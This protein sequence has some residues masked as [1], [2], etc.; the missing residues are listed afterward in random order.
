MNEPANK[1]IA[2]EY[3]EIQAPESQMPFFLDCYESF[4]W[5][6]DSRLPHRPGVLTV[7]RDRRRCNKAELTR[8]QRHFEACMEEITALENS[9]TTNATMAAIAAGVLATAF[10]A[11]SVFAVTAPQPRWFLGALLGI[12]GIAGWALT[13]LLYKKLTAKRAEA[14]RGLVDEKYEEI[15]QICEKGHSLL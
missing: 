15:Y 13:P 12:P 10:V 11:A 5:E 4:G 2:Y 8:L 1:Y 9:K 7:R 14:V 3:R 6:A